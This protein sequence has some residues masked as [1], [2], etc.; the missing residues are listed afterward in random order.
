M[1]ALKTALALALVASL[2]QVETVPSVTP[3]VR[4][5]HSLASVKSA[6]EQ[7]FANRSGVHVSTRTRS[8][9]TWVGVTEIITT[10][11]VYRFT[12]SGISRSDIT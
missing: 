4:A 9:Y 2:P 6:V 7:Q 5:G 1:I 3:V 8:R 10:K 12:R 11:G